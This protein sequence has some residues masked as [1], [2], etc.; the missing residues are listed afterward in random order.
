[1]TPKDLVERYVQDVARRLPREMRADVAAELRDLMMDSVNERA[2]G[3][4]PDAALVKDFLMSFGA[5][6][7][8]AL[9]YHAAPA[10]IE[11]V[12]ARLFVK[13]ALAL[14]LALGVLTISVAFAA[15]HLSPSELRLASHKLAKDAV[16][17][18]F[19][20]LGVLVALFWL[21]GAA[22]RLYPRLAAWDPAALPPVRDPD[23]IN[24]IGYALAIG[25]WTLGL[26]IL[27]RPIGLFDLL[28][29]G[30]TPPALQH[31]FA[32][33]DAF[34]RQRAP[35]LWALLG[36][37]ILAI[38]WATLEGRWRPLT[39]RVNV[40]VAIALCAVMGWVVLAG[41]IFQAAPANQTMKFATALLWGFTLID[42]WQKFID[43]RHEQKARPFTAASAPS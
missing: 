2:G 4:E 25:F 42:T 13:L 40:G 19:L 1:M 16:E 27:V 37:Q 3:R 18:A 15:P 7:E 12:D 6:A 32:Y 30:R 29:S 35:L 31:A 34:S 39:R 41:D 24:R 17:L 43:V 9:R 22:R 38:A 5:P 36:C 10:I 28:M 23:H 21:L 20:I 11:P 14:L 8:V 33:D 26:F